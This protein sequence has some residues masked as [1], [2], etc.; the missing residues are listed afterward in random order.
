MDLKPLFDW[1][2][3]TP[4]LFEAKPPIVSTP[5]FIHNAEVDW[6]PYR[7]NRRLGF[8]Y[9]HLCSKLFTLAPTYSSIAEEIQ[10]NHEG[11][12]IGAVD[13]ILKNKKSEQFEHWEVAV[14]FYLLH[15]GFW[16]G[17]NAQD[18]LDLKLAHMLE[19]QLP[20]SSHE[21]FS[22]RYPLWK[23]AVPRLLMQGRLYINP[24][25]SEPTPTECGGYKL[26]SSQI[27]GH[28]CYQSQVDQVEERLY[29]I[30]K[31]QW[32]TGRNESS[33]IYTPSESGFVHCQSESGVFWFI[34]PEEWPKN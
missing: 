31:S 33:P 18:R 8:V 22:K 1:V 10:L 2:I 14:K 11:K 34:M 7:G 24:F 15:Q 4:S 25:N 32:L 12:T 19:H 26:N 29:V 30:E 28:W 16:Y 21:Q 27:S 20:L 6:G 3:T 9:Q 5:P 13:F 17:P 23:N